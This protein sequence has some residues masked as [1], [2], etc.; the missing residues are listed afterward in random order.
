MAIFYIWRR[1]K[2][3]R[4]CLKVPFIIGLIVCCV[5]ESKKLVHTAG[6]LSEFKGQFL[7]FII[8]VNL[9]LSSHFLYFNQG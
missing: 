1:M 3:A 4:K 5:V 6:V 2:A 8:L 7:R 9:Y